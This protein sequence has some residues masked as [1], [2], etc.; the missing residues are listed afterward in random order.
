MGPYLRKGVRK[1]CIG[2]YNVI[3]MCL[4]LAQEIAHI[5]WD[6]LYII[7]YLALYF[8]KNSLKLSLNFA[9]FRPPLKV[10]KQFFF[11]QTT[12]SV[13]A[14]IF[15]FVIFSPFLFSFLTSSI[16]YSAKKSLFLLLQNTAQRRFIS[17]HAYLRN[18]NR[19]P[20]T[21]LVLQHRL[22]ACD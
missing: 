5:F 13:V 12:V 15:E 17:C 11:F 2:T 8:N 20:F 10:S 18:R 14:D 1:K 21:R 22:Q 4:I 3:F 9:L 19:T 7:T 16:F 6:S